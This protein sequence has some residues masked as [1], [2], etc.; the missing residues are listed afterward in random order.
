MKLAALPTLLILLLAPF[1]LAADCGGR[2][3]SKPSMSV[4]WTAREAACNGP[5]Y[6]ND[7]RVEIAFSGSGTL[8]TQLCWDVTENILNQCI[9]NGEI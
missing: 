7:P 3:L 8:G 5:K 9:S 6:F 4:F 1:T 2:K